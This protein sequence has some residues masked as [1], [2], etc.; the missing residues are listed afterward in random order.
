MTPEALQD[1]LLAAHARGATV[2]LA[3]LY[4]V[5]ADREEHAGRIDAACFFLTHAFVFALEA[6]LPEADTLNKRLADHGRA[7]RLDVGKEKPDAI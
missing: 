6:G 3:R 5:A 7:E 2:D 4:A 1:A